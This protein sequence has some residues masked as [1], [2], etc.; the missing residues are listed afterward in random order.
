[1]RIYYMFRQWPITVP[2]QL[3]VNIAES[4]GPKKHRNVARFAWRLR[5]VSKEQQVKWQ[6]HTGGFGVFPS[7]YSARKPERLGSDM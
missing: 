2:R 4:L 5:R 7:R 1:M 6:C 3:W